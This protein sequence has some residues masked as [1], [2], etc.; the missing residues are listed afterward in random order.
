MV[1]VHTVVVFLGAT[2]GV[3]VEEAVPSVFGTATGLPES[4]SAEANHQNQAGQGTFH[5]NSFFEMIPSEC[6]AIHMAIDAFH[7]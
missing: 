1:V 7:D 3:I 5:A 4:T 2:R 6:A